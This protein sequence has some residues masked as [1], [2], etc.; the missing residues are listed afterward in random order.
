MAIESFIMTP[1]FASNTPLFDVP[2]AKY[3]R[4]WTLTTWCHVGRHVDW[5]FIEI[6]FGPSCP[7]GLV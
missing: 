5:S 2:N 3:D 7:H 4:P 6:F 1:S